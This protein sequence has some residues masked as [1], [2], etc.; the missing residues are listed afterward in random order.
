MTRRFHIGKP[1]ASQSCGNQFEIENHYLGQTEIA[2]WMSIQRHNV[3]S[4]VGFAE[5]GREAGVTGCT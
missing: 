4:L 3:E 5:D 2:F 1:R